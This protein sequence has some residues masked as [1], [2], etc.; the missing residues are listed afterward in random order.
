MVLSDNDLMM[1]E[2]LTYLTGKD[3]GYS[4]FGINQNSKNKTVGDILSF[5]TEDKLQEMEKDIDPVAAEQKEAG[6]ITK[7]EWASMIRYMQN[8]DMKD[9]VLTD[10]MK[11]KEGATIAYCF[12]E[13]GDKESAI[14][15]FRGTYGGDEWKDNVEGLNVSD[16]EKQ[17]EALDF[18]ESLEYNDVTV[19]G[20]SKGGNKAMYVAITS[21]KVTRCVSMDGQGFSQEFIDKYWAEIQEKKGIIKNYSLQSDFV[22]ILLFPIPGSEQIYCKGYDHGEGVKGLGQNHSSNSFFATDKFG[23]LVD[24]NGNPITGQGECVVY[25]GQKEDPS[26]TMLHEFTTFVLNNASDKDK[27]KIVGFLSE[28]L[29]KAMVTYD[30]DPKKNQEMMLEA[31]LKHISDN[32]EAF[33]YVLAYLVKYMDEYDLGADDIDALLDMLALNTSLNELVNIT[34]F[35]IPFSDTHVYVNLNLAN[36]LEMVKDNLTDGND[37][38]FIKWLLKK[39]TK[40]IREKYDID[41]A[42]IWDVTDGKVQRIKVKKGTENATAHTGEVHE[43][44]AKAYNA[45][46]E[47]IKAYMSES[48]SVSDWN[49][50]SNQEWYSSMLIA[51]AVKGINTFYTRLYDVNKICKERVE[52]VFTEA[53]NADF[54]WSN[55]I[56]AKKNFLHMEAAKITNIL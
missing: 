22:H 5:F 45:L 50:Y 20:H 24:S 25:G 37:D 28:L 4:E 52:K 2:Q 27:A 34:D 12:A 38:W 9:L 32:Q 56:Q 23:R 51:N 46:T 21:D 33:G 18:I 54:K 8:S 30:S 36:I 39:F 40:S 19:V 7:A 13:E 11:N 47:A 55:T 10:T 3:V 44:S 15:T 43:F 1:L 26:A 6:S 49:Q 41:I 35:K 53:E 48:R 17:K 29:S 16:T 14:V 42:Y 31:V